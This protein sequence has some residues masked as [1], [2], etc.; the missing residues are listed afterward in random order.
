MSIYEFIPQQIEAE[1]FDGTDI[2]KIVALVGEG[3][4]S[5]TGSSLQVFTE[6]GRWA[7]VFP[8]WW[9][10]KRESGGIVVR[11]D[12]AFSPEWRPVSGLHAGA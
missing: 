11:S 6:D 7:D 9:V 5:F 3:S 4:F 12:E 2:A 1:Q 8:G 10:T